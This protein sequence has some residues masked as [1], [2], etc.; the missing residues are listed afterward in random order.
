MHE[1]PPAGQNCPTFSLYIVFFSDSSV[2]FSLSAIDTKLAGTRLIF[3]YYIFMGVFH[4]KM[5][6][7]FAYL[8]PN[9]LYLLFVNLYLYLYILLFL[10]LKI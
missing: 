2:K 1:I 6:E 10:L 9:L 3:T 4:L 5:Y 7:D 8:I